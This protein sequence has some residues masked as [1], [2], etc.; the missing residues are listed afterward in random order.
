VDH[1]ENDLGFL[2]QARQ[3]GRLGFAG[4]A[5]VAKVGKGRGARVPTA[6][7]V[8]ADGQHAVAGTFQL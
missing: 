3:R 6:F 8:D 1:R 2:D 5:A 4:T 7:A